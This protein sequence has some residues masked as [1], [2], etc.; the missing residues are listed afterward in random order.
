MRAAQEQT[1]EDLFEKIKPTE[2]VKLRCFI[3][4]QLDGR[5]HDVSRKNA[6]ARTRRIRVH[7][8]GPGLQ[9]AYLVLLAKHSWSEGSL[10]LGRNVESSRTNLALVK[11]WID[12]CHN[13]HKDICESTYNHFGD[14][15]EESFFGIIDVD[16]MCLTPLPRGRRYIALSYTWKPD[17]LFKT[18]INTVNKLRQPGGLRDVL[19]DMPRAVRDSIDLVRDLGERY[20]WVDSICIVQDD[21][22]SWE[23]NA[24]GMDSVYGHADLTICAADDPDASAGLVALDSSRRIFSQHIEEYRPGLSLMVSHLSETYINRSRWNTRGWTFQERLLSRRCLLFTHGRVY[25]QCQATAMSEDIIS[26]KETAGWSIELGHA[27]LHLLANLNE[28]PIALYKNCVELYT[29]RSLTRSEDILAAFNGISNLLGGRLNA[30]FVFGLPDSHFDWSLLWEP[31]AASSHRSI[32]AQ[33]GTSGNQNRPKQMRFPTWSWSGWTGVMEYHHA[34]LSGPSTNLHTWL[35]ERTWII[36]YIRD[37]LGRLRMIRNEPPE[38]GHHT[39]QVEHRWCGYLSEA[40]R[41][42]GLHHQYDPYGRKKKF[43]DQDG[44]VFHRTLPGPVFPYGVKMASPDAGPNLLRP[45]K[46]YLQFWTWSARFRISQQPVNETPLG[47]GLARFDIA[48]RNGDWCGTIV[49]AHA[50]SSEID[51]R[52]AHEFIALSE[53]KNFA[54]EEYDGWTYYQAAERDESEWDLYYVLLIQHDEEEIAHRIGLG[55]IY[56][57]AFSRSCQG[58]QQWKELLLG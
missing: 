47:E 44:T 35:M 50:Q 13:F 42:A 31:R 48:D 45:D 36:W 29:T 10:F 55:K 3:S 18:T 15:R 49:L 33:A 12:L 17:E 21:L 37:G 32:P 39:K 41:D 54:D 26:E 57:E 25:F 9:D 2:L 38:A 27:P 4:W 8:D 20:L 14:M 11:S 23:L 40:P 6:L 30:H 46:P 28:K 51:L 24:A 34:R 53:A 1:Q 52:A 43:P 7:W 16:M 22:D 58:E 56:K 19:D 5:N